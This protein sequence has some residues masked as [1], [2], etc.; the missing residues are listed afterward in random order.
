MMDAAG[1]VKHAGKTYR[2]DLLARNMD[3]DHREE[4]HRSPEADGNPQHF[5]DEFARRYPDE[6]EHLAEITPPVL[7]AAP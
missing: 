5:W 1:T 7:D 3:D 4:I 2:L 6:A